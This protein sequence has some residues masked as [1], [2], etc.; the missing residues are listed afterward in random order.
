MSL[1]T[2]ASFL[3]NFDRSTVVFVTDQFHCEKLIETGSRI[4]KATR[5]TLQVVNI[6]RPSTV[7]NSAAIEHLYRI[8]RKFGAEMNVFYEQDDVAGVMSRCL[9]ELQ[10][11]HA[12]TGVPQSENSVVQRIWRLH[13]AINFYTVTPEGTMSEVPLAARLPRN[14]AE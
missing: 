11:C 7:A 6:E 4:A 8:S 12:V 14:T 9:L 13:T 10:A 5:T 2:T 1:Q 3:D